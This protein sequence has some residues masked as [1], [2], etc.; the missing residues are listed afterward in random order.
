MAK[1]KALTLKQIETFHRKKHTIP[2]I[3]MSQ[4][5]SHEIIYGTRALNKRL[6]G[7]L[8]KPTVDYD[9][10][11]KTPRKD[12]RQ[13]EK[14]LD[15]V[16]G[17]DYFYVEPALHK[18]TYKVKAHANKEGYVDYTKP[19]K[20]IPYDLINGKKYIQLGAVKKHIKR[21]LKDKEAKFRHDKD[22]DALNRIRVHERLMQQQA[23]VKKRL[24]K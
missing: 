21:T 23:K 2:K 20:K 7:F 8:D 14:A 16:F 15:K 6:P 11:S 19:E 10:Y 9:I 4:T 17:G 5:D 24:K 3:I 12:A 18:G 22:R 13:S 1:R